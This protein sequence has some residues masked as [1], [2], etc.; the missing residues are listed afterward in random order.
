MGLGMV[1]SVV[2]F[3]LA[4]PTGPAGGTSRSGPVLTLIGDS[5][6][7]R[8]EHDE[9][10]L[11]RLNSG[12]TLNLQTHGC[13]RLATASCAIA[14]HDAGPPPNVVELARQLGPRL[15]R[16]VVLVMGYNDDPA[17][18]DRDLDRV[19]R[20][21][22]REGVRRV[23]MLTLR[24][25]RLAYVRSNRAIEAERTEWPMLT[26]ADWNAYSADRP[27]WFEADGLH[28]TSKGAMALAVFVRAAARRLP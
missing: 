24:E 19:M 7:D 2:A 9:I 21:L 4:W 16:I 5:V 14:G 15:G 26:V 22:L 18:I 10:A 23:V 28:L 8:I 6:A 17:R 12:F 25:A 27:D 3:T 20:A 1:L 11:R 13:R